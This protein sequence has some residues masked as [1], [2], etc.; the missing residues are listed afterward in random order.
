MNK[1][2]NELKEIKHHSTVADIPA[3]FSKEPTFQCLPG[4]GIVRIYSVLLGNC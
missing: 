1:Q 4:D 3:L 2:W